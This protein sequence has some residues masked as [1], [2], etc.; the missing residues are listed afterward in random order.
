MINKKIL[1]CLISIFLITASIYSQSEEN[2]VSIQISS[3]L[4]ASFSSYNTGYVNTLNNNEIS[5]A[6]GGLGSLNF[7]VG[8]GFKKNFELLGSIGFVADGPELDNGT[9]NY[10]I[11]VYQSS[12]KYNLL[13][14]EKHF[15]YAGGG[16]AFYSKPTLL[17]DASQVQG[18]DKTE[19]FYKSSI[20][21][22]ICMSYHYRLSNKLDF[23]FDVSSSFNRF[24]L[25]SAKINNSDIEIQDLSS[26]K[27]TTFSKIGASNI[28]FQIGLAFNI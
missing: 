13:K 18:G 28:E 7:S 20:S 6:G 16:F 23:L 2:Y 27:K 3:G 12:L 10:F 25:K 9:I 8:Y 1:T 24:D 11:T 4:C 15:L 17:I 19:Y 14:S 5:I 21:P 22:L 26:Q